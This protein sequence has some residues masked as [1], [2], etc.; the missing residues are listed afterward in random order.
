MR[1][2]VLTALTAGLILSCAGLAQDQDEEQDP[3]RGVARISLISGDVTVR[4]GDSGDWTAA[5]GNSPVLASDQVATGTGARAEVQFDY[6]TMVR[7][8]GDTEIRLAQVDTKRYQVQLGRGTAMLA[9]L[10]DADSDIEL[11]TP[12]VAIRPGKRALVRVTVTQDG[13]SE[14]TVR[15][16][17]AEISTPK[18]VERVRAGQTMMVRGEQNDPEFQMVRA[19]EWDSFDKW[20]QDRDKRLERS[21]SYQYVSPDI[22]GADE[23]DSSGRWINVPPYGLV[24]TPYG[25]AVDWAPY[26]NGRWSWMDYYGW[27][28]VS[29]DPWGWAPYHY[30]RWFN[31]A[32]YGWC[33]YPGGIHSRHYWRPGLVAFFGFGSGFGR[34]GWVPLAPYERYHPWYGRG[35]YGGYRNGVMG[36][37]NI[38]VMHD[39]NIRNVY[40]NARVA[41][42]VS[43]IEAGDFVRGRSGRALAAG[44][45]DL[46]RASLVRGALPVTP[47]AESLRVSDRQVRSQN[48]PRLEGTR[49]YSRQKAPAVERI[50]FAQQQRSMEQAVNRSFGTNPGGQSASSAGMRNEA[51]QPATGWRRVGEPPQVQPAQT[52]RYGAWRQPSGGGTTAPRGD[53]QRGSQGASPQY[54]RSQPR[55][56]APS[57]SAPRY[58][59]SQ[60]I[61]INP[62]I[63]R[64]RSAPSQTPRYERS[65]ANGGG[66]ARSSSGGGGG[67]HSS[68]G[69]GGGRSSGG[70]SSGRSR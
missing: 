31:Q 57:P 36:H 44:S 49:F 40:R 35:Q 50:P 32:G 29:Y 4:R 47:R 9:V 10:R 1:R 26:R 62:P 68:G 23:L 28:W 24:W 7:L 34:V 30:G 13:Q 33:W 64:E 61:R 22:S 65:G 51:G 16:G 56:Q 55:Y 8:S 38:N 59:R 5:A 39:T 20:N 46:Q 19:A 67:G 25:V 70:H 27:S 58:E 52:G 66:G 12:N 43:G 3:G 42:G 18:G 6:A 41:N 15:E 60:P 21:S 11:D 2:T 45:A 69:G 48:L 17:D 14:I 63:V 54:D 53:W 37:N